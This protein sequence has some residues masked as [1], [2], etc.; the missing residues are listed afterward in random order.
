MNAA[1]FRRLEAQ[2]I[3][4]EEF[5]LL[6]EGL[7][8]LELDLRNQLRDLIVGVVA[9]R[10]RAEQTERRVPGSRSPFQN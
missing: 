5:F 2:L 7:S 3:N 6:Q 1:Q 9:A 4:T 8:E 10:V